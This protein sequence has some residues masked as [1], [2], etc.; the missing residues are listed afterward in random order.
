MQLGDDSNG[1]HI[2][3][4]VGSENGLILH[5]EHAAQELSKTP[6]VVRIRIN[7]LKTATAKP[8]PIAE[9]PVLPR[10]AWPI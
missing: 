2:V 8:V 7:P 10:F 5:T 4:I 1:G 6:H 9:M 3:S